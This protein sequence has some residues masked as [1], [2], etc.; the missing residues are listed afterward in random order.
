MSAILLQ[1]GV[2]HYEV[3]GRGRP[4]LMLHGWVG[5]WRYWI[6]SM[7]SAA[8]RFRAYALDF[9]GFGDTDRRPEHYTLEAQVALLAGFLDRMGMPKVALVGHGLGAVVAM[10][11]A[12]RWPHLVDRLMAVALPSRRDA[13]S[14]RLGR[15]DPPGLA[16]WLLVPTPA[17]EAARLEAPKADPQAIRTSLEG[18]AALDVAAAF[19]AIQVPTLL[20]YGLKDPLVRPPDR[21]VVQALPPQIHEITFEDSGHF[22]MLD[23]GSKFHRLLFDFLTLPSGESPRRLQL[24]EEWK[25]RVR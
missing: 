20:V 5:S 22:P 7:Q 12:Q 17:T 11:F 15:E 4:V 6:P 21:V 13:V 3:L 23:Q 18:L 24:K 10:L 8:M 16:S 2:V 9:W 1:G 14:P 19:Q 25:R